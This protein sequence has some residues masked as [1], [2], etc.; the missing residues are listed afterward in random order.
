MKKRILCALLAFAML[1]SLYA[2]STTPEENNQQNAS[3]AANSAADDTSLPI[4][5]RVAALVD[6]MTIEEKAAQMVEGEV[7]GVGYDYMQYINLGSVLRGGGSLDQSAATAQDWKNRINTYQSYAMQ[8]ST[9]IP[10]LFAIDAVHGNNKIRGAV[11][12]PHNI[13]V[14]AAN[15][16]ELTRQMGEAVANEM[17]LAGMHLNFAPCVA[18]ADDPRWGRTYESYSTESDIVTSLSTAYAEG[19]L[20]EGVMP[21]AKH[22]IADGNTN[23]GTGTSGT[24]LDRGDST[25]TEEEIR[26]RL[27]PAYESLIDAGVMVIMPSFRSIDGVKMHESKY[28]LTDVLK[29]ELGFEGFLITDYD[30]LQLVSGDTYEDK[31]VNTVNAG[32][33]MLMEASQY[34]TAVKTIIKAANSGRISEERINDAVT[35]ILRVKFEMGLYD[36]PR[37]EN[38]DVKIDELGSDEYRDIARQLVEKSLVLLKNEGNVLPLKDVKVY[39]DGPALDDVGVACGGWTGSWQGQTDAEAGALATPG[40]TILDGLKA[41]ASE[42]GVTIITDPAKISEADVVLIAVGER[43]YAEWE[44]DSEDISLTGALALEGNKDAIQLAKKSG[45]PTIALIVAGR[46][47]MINEYLGDW[48]AAVMCY[49]PGSEGDGV[50]NVLYGKTGFSG[51]LP[52]PWY[53]SVKEI[54]KDDAKLLFETG[55]GLTY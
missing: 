1:L 16:P 8:S 22:F 52:M 2:C 6:S 42:Y 45:K 48:D 41:S 50:A 55:Y 21:T 15:D 39:V 19:L 7:D 28:W 40:T 54:G 24:I 4:D 20:A 27:L 37:W 38:I 35:R 32:M 9:P 30:G 47:V 23:Y 46:N 18:L 5:E 51:K 36:D 53:E 14:G 33:D 44:G 34:N 11:I 12:F 10:T 25:L 31:L 17:K 13:G 26:E 43:P 49:L 29:D 3:S